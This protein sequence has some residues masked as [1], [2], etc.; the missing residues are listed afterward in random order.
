MWLLSIFLGDFSEASSPPRRGPPHPLPDAAY[1]TICV[2]GLVQPKSLLHLIGADPGITNDLRNQPLE[3]PTVSA[4]LSVLIAGFFNSLA[5]TL[6]LKSVN[7]TGAAEP[8]LKV[9]HERRARH[10]AKVRQ[11]R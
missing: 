6:I 1:R 2:H 8:V 7:R 3:Y 4:T 10:T 9:A 5:V 11:I